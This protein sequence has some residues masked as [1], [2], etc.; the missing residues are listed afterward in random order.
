MVAP[1]LILPATAQKGSSEEQESVRW[2]K[3]KWV[4][5][6]EDTAK[7]QDI[8]GGVK[9]RKHSGK[10]LESCLAQSNNF[11][12]STITTVQKRQRQGCQ[13]VKD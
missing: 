4:F 8:Q 1:N 9:I 11:T 5:L 3:G 2:R 12:N 6:V 7:V 13:V 10:L